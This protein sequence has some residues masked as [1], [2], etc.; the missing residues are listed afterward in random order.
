MSG[1]D[2]VKVYHVGMRSPMKRSLTARLGA[3]LA[4]AGFEERV[5][6]GDLV[7]VKVHFGETGNTGFV[8]PI[9]L[10]EVVARIREYGGKPFLTDANTL[11]RGTRAN[12]VDHVA[13][14]LHN[15][16]SWATVEAPVI[17]ADGLDG[18]EGCDVAIEGFKHFETVRI[19]SAAV[20]ADGLV[21]V[22]HFKGH[23]AT[24]F[25]G[26]LKN[27]GMGLGTRS[28]KQRMHSDLKPQVAAEKCTACGRCVSSCPV[29]AIVIGP[30]RVATIDPEVCYGCGECVA[31]CPFDSIG[32]QWKTDADAIQ[33]K[34]VEHMAGALAGKD[35]KT[36]FVNFV[37]SV[38]PDC[39]CW[40]FSDAPLVPDMGVLC[41]TDP[42]ALD[43]ASLDLVNSVSGLP[44]SRAEGMEPGVDKFAKITGVDGTLGL[45]Y[46]ERMGLGS[47]DYELVNA[48]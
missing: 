12:A 34:I 17:I 37:T 47:R 48:Q 30:D 39:D 31:Q 4:R 6:E 40:A 45:A 44:G 29:S 16:F 8:R 1:L 41:S 15:G 5:G 19:G 10:R 46:A 14:A 32:I 36:M 25:G 28:A 38:T 7:A 3:M 2:R 42:V 18:R 11:Y 35:G 9:F 22:T 27:I 23:E 21:A 13:T 20:H 26:T 43:Q 33:E 24:G